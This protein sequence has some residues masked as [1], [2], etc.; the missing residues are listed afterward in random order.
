M[1]TFCKEIVTE[2]SAAKNEGELIKIISY[3]M[4]RLRGTKNSNDEFGYLITIIASLRSI[5]VTGLSVET[6]NN[7]RL[8]IAIFRQFQKENSERVS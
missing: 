7:I 5:D 8:A 6:Q 2:I 4:S 1:E 3:S